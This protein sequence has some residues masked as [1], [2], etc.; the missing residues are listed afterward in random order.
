MTISV[1]LV[2]G[3]A[4]QSSKTDLVN[5]KIITYKTRQST[6]IDKQPFFVC[7]LAKALNL[8][9]GYEL[10]ISYYLLSNKNIFF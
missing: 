3:S 8:R 6:K 7:S 1:M 5:W 2:Q 9:Y 4:N 10:N